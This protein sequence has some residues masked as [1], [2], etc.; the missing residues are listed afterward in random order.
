MRMDGVDVA[1]DGSFCLDDLDAGTYFLYAVDRVGFLMWGPKHIRDNSLVPLDLADG[2]QK[3]SYVLQVAT[4]NGEITGRVVD[5][6]GQPVADAYVRAV[7][8][9]H[10]TGDNEGFPAFNDFEP[11]QSVPTDG[12]GQFV[13]SHLRAALYD[14]TATGYRGEGSGKVTKVPVGKQIEIDLHR[15]GSV[16]G[17]ARAPVSPPCRVILHDANAPIAS[18]AGDGA[19]C[20]FRIDRVPPGNY[21]VELIANSGSGTS[22]AKVVAGTETRVEVDVDGW[23]RIN[24]VVQD[25]HGAPISGAAV[26]SFSDDLVPMNIAHELALG[27]F[28]RTGANGAFSLSRVRRGQVTIAILTAAG[29]RPLWVR[30]VA[31]EE[32]VVDL[33]IITATP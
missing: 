3:M 29:N 6:E 32:R 22:P 26:L 24:G 9:N 19:R 5:D 28:P 20:S 30:R 33:G 23:S 1:D 10:F 21:T 17:S 12:D 2:E 15:T 13:L 7:V 25:A 14:V 11:E 18:T 8:L 4:R 27:H 16:H 31:V